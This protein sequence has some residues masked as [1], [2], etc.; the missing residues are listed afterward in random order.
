M[1]AQR[2][3]RSPLHPAQKYAM[4]IFENILLFDLLHDV[5]LDHVALLDV[6]ELLEVQA[7]LVAGGDLLDRVLEALEGGEMALVD[8]DAVTHDARLAGALDLAVGDVA[9]GDGADIGHLEGLA[10]T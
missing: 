10:V 4:R 7:A 1:R 2:V 9:A 5:G 8:D 3:R 6:V